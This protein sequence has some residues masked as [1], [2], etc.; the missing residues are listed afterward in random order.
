MHY[1][2]AIKK[3]KKHHLVQIKVLLYTH[4]SDTTHNMTT[5]KEIAEQCCQL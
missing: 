3:I 1:W 2:Y 4:S 5:V